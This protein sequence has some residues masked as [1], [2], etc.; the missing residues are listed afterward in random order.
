MICFVGK[1]DPANNEVIELFQVANIPDNEVAKQ[2]N[3]KE[4]L[5]KWV[6]MGGKKGQIMHGLELSTSENKIQLANSFH[7]EKFGQG[8]MQIQF[9]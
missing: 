4:V 2:C 6:E 5:D 1:L 3:S 9:I 7:P 8:K